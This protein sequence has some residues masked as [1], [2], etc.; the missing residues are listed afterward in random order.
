MLE[1]KPIYVPMTDAEVER[2]LHYQDLTPT[3]FIKEYLGASHVMLNVDEKGEVEITFAYSGGSSGSNSGIERC[4]LASDETP[5]YESV[6]E[7]DD[8][9][10][11]Q[12]IEVVSL[13]PGDRLGNIKKLAEAMR[14]TFPE[15]GYPK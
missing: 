8:D 2:M 3:Q 5:C 15:K 9:D 11:F 7:Y 13:V 4:D 1:I 14:L 6:E 10:S 12:N